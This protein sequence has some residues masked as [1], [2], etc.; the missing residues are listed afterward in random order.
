MQRKNKFPNVGSETDIENISPIISR[1]DPPQFK[2]S[3]FERPSE[4]LHV[5]ISGGEISRI[6]STHLHLLRIRI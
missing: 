3:E 2:S 6:L 5:R 1:N 4:L